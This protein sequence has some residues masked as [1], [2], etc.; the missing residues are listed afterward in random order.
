MAGFAAVVWVWSYL[1]LPETL[2][3]ERRQSF[4]PAYLARTYAQVMRSPAFLAACLALTFGFSGFF[5]YVLSAPVFLMQHLKVGETEFLWLFGPVTLGLLT[6]AWLS[7]RLAG[8]LSPTRTVLWGL[9]AMATAAAGNLTLN[10]VSSPVLPWAVAPLYL[11]ASGMALSTPSLT[12]MALDLFPS[13]RGL[14]SSC[15]GFIQS[16]GNSL[17]AAFIAPVLW[18]N[19]LRLA[20]GEAMFC[21]LAAA[22]LAAHLGSAGSST[23]SVDRR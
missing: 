8:R 3:P 15:Q 20:L 16:L 23:P 13:Q 9:A 18:A 10:L 1:K 6:G 12:L 4:R 7:G 17:N 2:P 14:A 11:Y 22:A 21:L 5:V 19:P